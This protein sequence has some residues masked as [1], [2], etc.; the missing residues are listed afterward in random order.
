M[1]LEKFRLLL[2]LF[3]CLSLFQSCDREE[4]AK[5][6]DLTKKEQLSVRQEENVVTYA[7]LP[8]YSHTV[9]YQRHHPLVEFLSQQTGLNIKQIFPDTFDEH[10]KMVGQG[11]IDIS[12]SNP[13]I[14]L[15]IAH[16]YAARAFA[17][18]LEIYGQEN[19]R[20]QIICR[21][22]NLRIQGI[23]DCRGKRWIAVDP[24]SAGG[25]L[26]P[27]GHFLEH[28]LKKE[29][30]SEIAF[31][32]GPGG[33]QEKVVLAVYAGKYDI[34]TIREGTLTVVAD[35]IDINEIRV[36]AH[37][38]WYPG[39]VYAARSD[40]KTEIVQIIKNALLKLDYNQTEHKRML[41]AADIVGF[42]P[43]EDEDFDPVRELAARIG[44]NLEE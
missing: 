12:Y 28:G 11:K 6:V 32:P 42:I 18:T 41:D 26:Y 39:W 25:Y 4:P 2:G 14:Y 1:M 44:M 38:R 3:L 13:F 20:G 19:F 22:D 9:S 10:M 31:T 7:Y 29:D 35:K 21:A 16:R 37:T 33:K 17:R 43:S 36:I 5:K 23:A 15:K 30:F 24:T 27:L 34:G 8:Q 40:L